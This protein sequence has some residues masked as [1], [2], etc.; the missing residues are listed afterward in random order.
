MSERDPIRISKRDE[1]HPVRVGSIAALDL[2]FI[3][4]DLRGVSK[5]GECYLIEQ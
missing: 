3:S 4:R 2:L 1:R 5:I